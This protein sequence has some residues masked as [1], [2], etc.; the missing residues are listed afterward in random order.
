M[1]G[2]N[3]NRAEDTTRQRSGLFSKGSFNAGDWFA[4]RYNNTVGDEGFDVVEWLRE[5]SRR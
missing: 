5:V 3:T 1:K 2:T 4:T